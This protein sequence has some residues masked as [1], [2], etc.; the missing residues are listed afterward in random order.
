MVTVLVLDKTVN[1]IEGSDDKF[2]THTRAWRLQKQNHQAALMALG[3]LG[4][5]ETSRS[6]GRIV[7]MF[8]E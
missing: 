8:A 7:A 5:R 6:T 4:K 2:G 1:E 3:S